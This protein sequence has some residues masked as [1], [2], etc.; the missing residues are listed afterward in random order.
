MAKRIEKLTLKDFRGATVPL[1]I[2]FD[3]SK[4]MAMIFGENATGKSSIVDALDFVCN[5][6]YGSIEERSSIKKKSHL[7]AIGKKKNDVCVTLKYDSKEWTANHQGAEPC[8]S[9][10]GFPAANILRRSNILKVIDA[11]PNQ[12]YDNL[13]KFLSVPN[14]EKCEGTLRNAVLR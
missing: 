10:T 14:I 8:T 13:A 1:E 4:P 5:Q 2:D 9:P 3:K 12:R 6:R 11:Q 7:P